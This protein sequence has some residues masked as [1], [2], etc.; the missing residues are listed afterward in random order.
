MIANLNNWT[1][2]IPPQRCSDERSER[3]RLLPKR[4]S[5]LVSFLLNKVLGKSRK[6]PPYFNE[7]M[8]SSFYFALKFN[9]MYTKKH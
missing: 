7:E 2:K 6:N 1:E 8:N 3:R 9:Y 4:L 5:W